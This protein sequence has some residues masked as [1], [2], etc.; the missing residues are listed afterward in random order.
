MPAHQPE[1]VLPLLKPAGMTSHDC[2]AKLRKI[3]KTKKVGHTGTLDPEVTGVLPVCVGRG[4]KIAQYMTDYPKAYE[5]EA[6][7]GKATA[8]EDA[9]G[10]T[11]ETKEVP[12][13][14]SAEQVETVLQ[15]FKGIIQQV[16]PM[17]SAVKVNGKKL[18]QYAREGIE[19]ER[20]VREA[21]IYE[22]K[23]LSH[24]RQFP[25][26][27]PAFSF[28]VRCSKGTYIRT[29][30]VDMGRKLGYP[31]HM[32]KLVRVASGPFQ[33][34]DCYTFEE[35]ETAAENGTV[36]EL[37]LPIEKAIG[38]FESIVAD[39]EMERRIKHGSVLPMAKDVQNNRFA[40]Y[41]EK[42]LCL[43]IYKQHPDKPHLMKP[44]KI[45]AV[46]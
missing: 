2:V 30:A 36:A 31:A 42:G 13:E 24:D 25:G 43:A 32:S 11:V 45:L 12:G 26:P 4:T 15:S 20:P 8:T 22:L 5:A 44:E 27:Y 39:E 9:Y 6:T 34:K 40:V 18:Y 21:N 46:E 37:F 19:V 23:L 29:L 3:L 35:I 28:F 33:L 17:F 14:I 38:H 10:E 7:I 16:P 1:G 41:N